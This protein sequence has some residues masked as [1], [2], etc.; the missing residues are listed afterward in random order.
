[1]ESVYKIV[2]DNE[3]TE[4]TEYSNSEVMEL[5]VSWPNVQPHN[6]Y[7]NRIFRSWK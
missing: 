2:S 1:M 4:I 5:T 7:T 6:K 3:E